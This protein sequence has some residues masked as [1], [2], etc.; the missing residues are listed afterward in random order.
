M[1]L[2]CQHLPS[3]PVGSE[4]TLVLLKEHSVRVAFNKLNAVVSCPFKST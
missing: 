1:L 3:Q 2:S 4:V